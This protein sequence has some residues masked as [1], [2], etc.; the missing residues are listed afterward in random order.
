[1]YSLNATITESTDGT[2]KPICVPGVVGLSVVCVY[3]PKN[4]AGKLGSKMLSAF[5]MPMPYELQPPARTKSCC[6]RNV[7]RAS[8][9]KIESNLI[10]AKLTQPLV[11]YFPTC[12]SNPQTVPN[13]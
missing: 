8:Y 13:C 1:G 11:K 6:S 3:S 7:R 5:A 9:D 12:R 4:T 2:A 10:H